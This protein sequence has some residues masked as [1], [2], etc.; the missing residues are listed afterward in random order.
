MRILN[1]YFSRLILLLISATLAGPGQADEPELCGA[2]SDEMVD[3]GVVATMVRA[4]EDGHLYRI[5]K[6]ASRMGFCVGGSLLGEV[7]GDFGDFEG[8]LALLPNADPGRALVLV[9]THS[10]E[11]HNGVT[12]LVAKGENFFDVDRYP[13]ILFVGTDFEWTSASAGRLHGNLTMRGT[14]RPVTFQVEFTQVAS[15]EDRIVVTATTDVNRTDFGMT[16]LE[17]I[18]SDRVRLCLRVA[19]QR[20]GT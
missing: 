14:T 17:K 16:G 13:E 15:A 6:A 7:H 11:T 12:N 10:L 8:G 1:S 20:V 2:F 18:V 19:A 3:S 4:A 9:R 5:D